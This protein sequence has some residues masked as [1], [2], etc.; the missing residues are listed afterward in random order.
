[1]RIALIEACNP[2]WQFKRFSYPLQ[3]GYLASYLKKNNKIEDI[4]IAEELEE[5]FAAKPEL[6]GISSYSLNYD[7]AV[8]F[9]CR[10]KEKLGIPVILGGCHIS[11]LPETFD[12]IFDV[13]VTGEGEETFSQ[14]VKLWTE[15]G[16]FEP[17]EM[18]KINGIIFFDKGNTVRTAPRETTRQLD[19]YPPPDRTLYK[20]RTGSHYI[21]TSR[22]C[23]FHCLFC[24]PRLMWKNSRFF[25]ARYVMNE[26][27]GI[28]Q[29]FPDKFT[30]LSVVDDLFIANKARLKTLR[31]WFVSSRLNEL[32]ILQGNVRADMIDD[33]MASMLADMNFKTVNFGAESGSEKILKYYNKKA[34]AQDNKKALEIL[35][36]HGILSIPSFIIGAPE[37]TEED[38]DATYNFIEENHDKMA[39]FEI[40]PL[41][42]MPGS[43]M[44][45]YAKNKGIVDNNIHWGRLEPLLLDFDPDSYFFLTEKISRDKF[46]EYVAKFQELY[47]K[48][49][50]G[51]MQFREMLI[52]QGA[53]FGI[54]KPKQSGE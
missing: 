30:H 9:A 53:K 16:K 39:G 46:T 42:P 3:L 43:Q 24:A 26:I 52:K 47:K 49:N 36:K 17:A 7:I 34:T 8:D 32:I 45:E 21:S 5:V 23:P 48:Y 12:P 20:I 19:R 13:A 37:E 14:L 15:N 10:I 27:L 35:S 41:I 6:V 38:L 33:E 25:S 28:I 4:I 51:A 2:D 22:G 1:M 54:R 31:D 11:A 29:Q 50:T 18:E 40:F 44:W